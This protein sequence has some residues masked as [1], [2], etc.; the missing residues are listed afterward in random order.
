[1]AI[2]ACKPECTVIFHINHTS[3]ATKK[4]DAGAPDAVADL[5]SRI[6]AALTT[7]VDE[8]ALDAQLAGTLRIDLEWLQYRAN[9]R[10][11]VML[12]RLTTPREQLLPRAEIAIDLRQL[13]PAL[14]TE[15]L[16]PALKILANGSPPQLE[17]GPVFFDGYVPLRD[18]VIWQFNRLF[19]QR[20]ADWEAASGRGF[21]AALPSYS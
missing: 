3:Q 17:D 5:S 19:W 4:A 2:T 7:L 21:E 14:V 1:M 10:E 13:D 12:R 15:Q 9:F 18:S 20:L 16:A 11:P 6:T 8:V